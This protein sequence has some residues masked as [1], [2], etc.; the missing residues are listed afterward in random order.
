MDL[1]SQEPVHRGEVYLV[2]LN[3]TRGQE[4]RKTRPCVV[5]SPDE[6]NGHLGTFIVAP[7]TSGSFDYVFRV[8]C[9]FEGRSGHVVPDQLRTVDRERLV[10]RLGSLEAETLARVLDVLQQM[11]AA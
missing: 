6:L 8:P 2:A 5:V 10:K 7:L 4:I 1:V 9:R 3:L 11:F